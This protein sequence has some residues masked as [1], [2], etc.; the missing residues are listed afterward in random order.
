[1][2]PLIRDMDLIRDL[3]L[4]IEKG[5][6]SFNIVSEEEA[7]AL[8]LPTESTLPREEAEKL[9]Y[10]LY[11]LGDGNFVKISEHGGGISFVETITWNGQEFLESIRDPVIWAKTKDGIKAGGAFTFDFIKALAKGFIK[12]QLEKQTGIELDI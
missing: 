7:V 10:H 9:R 1:M 4:R 8:G 5:E 6:R 3:M 11:L 12:K 2:A